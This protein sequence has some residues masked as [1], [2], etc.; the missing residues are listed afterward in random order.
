MS[1]KRNGNKISNEFKGSPKNNY[2]IEN[3]A[4]IPDIFCVPKKT[5][6]NTS[7]IRS[8]SVTTFYLGKTSDARPHQISEFIFRDYETKTGPIRKHVRPWTN[9]THITDKY[10]YKLRELVQ[11]GSSQELPY[12]CY[13][14]IISLCLLFISFL[15]YD[16]AAEF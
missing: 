16:H 3:D 9:D 10:I 1:L 2:D 12:S 14:V 5:R 15:I 7:I 11:I 13:T 6:G 8:R 4:G